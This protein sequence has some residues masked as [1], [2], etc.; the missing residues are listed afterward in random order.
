[1][2]FN[3][4]HKVIIDT[5]NIIQGEEF[6]EFLRRER[7][8]HLE[9]YIRCDARAQFWGSEAKRQ[10]EEIAKLDKRLNKVKRKHEG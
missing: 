8:R 5:L 9:I 3:K 7:S 10:F 4:H 2:K 1:M 6:V